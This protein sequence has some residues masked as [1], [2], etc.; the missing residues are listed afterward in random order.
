MKECNVCL[1]LRLL[2][3]VPTCH[4]THAVCG[5]CAARLQTCPFCRVEWR[6]QEKRLDVFDRCLFWNDTARLLVDVCF[7]TGW[8]FWSQDR[9]EIPKVQTLEIVRLVPLACEDDKTKS[10]VWV[11]FSKPMFFSWG[12]GPTASSRNYALS[13]EGDVLYHQDWFHNTQPLD[14]QTT[15]HPRT[16]KTWWHHTS[17]TWSNLRVEFRK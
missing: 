17:P 9:K 12:G 16:W 11:T 6:V 5:Q 14:P 2:F 7:F 8:S 13:P 1:D 3:V 15:H 4:A 10:L